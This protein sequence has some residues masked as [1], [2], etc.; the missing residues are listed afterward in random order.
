MQEINGVRVYESGEVI[1]LVKGQPPL[2][3]GKSD[4]AFGYKLQEIDGVLRWTHA[5]QEDYKSVVLRLG[6]PIEEIE[7][8]IQKRLSGRYDCYL[9]NNAC[10]G[11]CAPNLPGCRGMYYPGTT[12]ILFC[13]CIGSR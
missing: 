2:P 3:N 1:E 8:D 9:S 4:A 13:G 10:A 12:T 11:S 5:S 6:T 7:A